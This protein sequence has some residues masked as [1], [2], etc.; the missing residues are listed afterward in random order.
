MDKEKAAVK[1]FW[2]DASC[3]E[4][5]Y[6]SGNEREDFLQHANIR[7]ELE[8]EI[9]DFAEFERSTGKRVLE[10]GVG[11]GADHQ[12]F[13]EAGADLFGVD[14]T[15][16]ALRNT[17]TRFRAMGLGTRLANV[18][19]EH[20]PFKSD[21]FDCVYS[22][23]VLHVTPDTPT[24]IREVH[25]ILKPGGMAKIMIYHTHSIVGYMLWIRYALMRM[26]PWLSLAHIYHHYLESLGTK[27]YSVGEARKLFYQFRNIRTNVV[28]THGDLL[29]SNAGQRHEGLLLNMARRIWPRRLIKRFLPG[30]GLFLTLEAKK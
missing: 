8:P 28:M 25:R 5:L 7:Y 29:T 14:L 3:G 15:R 1:E 27:A 22:W 23:G 2:E 6:L 16:R 30:H 12:Q 20:Q 17:R 26:R 21:I 10:I 11:L 13:A 9:L 18:D 19:A 4:R 24:A